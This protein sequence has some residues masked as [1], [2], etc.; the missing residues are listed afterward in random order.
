M[1]PMIARRWMLALV[2]TVVLALGAVAGPWAATPAEAADA[3]LVFATVRAL[4]ENHFSEPDPSKLFAAALDGLRQTLARAGITLTLADLPSPINETLAR[5][6]FQTRFDQAVAAAEG[7]I[8]ETELQY[9]AARAAA[10][11]LKDSHTAFLTP[12]QWTATQRERQGQATFT[13]IGIFSLFRD[14]RFY[15]KHVIPGGPAA[16]A[17]LREFDRIVA[18]DGQSTE[19]MRRE[20]FSSRVRGPQGT[21]VMITVRRSGEA[22]SLT[23]TVTREP[24]VIPVVEHRMLEGQIGYIHLFQHLTQGASGQ[25][26]RALEELQRQGMRALVLDLRSNGGGLTSET[27]QIASLLLPAGLAIA[28]RETRREKTTDVTAGGPLLP[29][30]TPLTV[31]IDEGTASGGEILAAALQEYQRGPLVGQRTAGAVLGSLFFSL[32]GGAAVQ[33]AVQQVSTGKGVALEGN[34]VRPDVQVELTTDDLERGVD[35][36][37]RRVL[38]T[39]LQR[40][41]ARAA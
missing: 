18:V 19:G 37:L 26:R 16:R 30:S 28:V 2:L 3:S 17:G 20:E 13:G 14:D 1:R 6:E 41:L 38:Q 4:A 8:T 15:I 25:F 7:K 5:E 24:I 27:R 33:I 10:D 36:Q 9:A 31:M 11:N 34:G 40:A 32:P 12:E 21:T 39:L 29:P 22:N 35:S 23:I